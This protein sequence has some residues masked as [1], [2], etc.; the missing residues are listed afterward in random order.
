MTTLDGCVIMLLLLL[1]QDFE[2]NETSK[3]ESGIISDFRRAG[4]ITRISMLV[5]SYPAVELDF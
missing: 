2:C 1:L 4:T 5:H 3:K